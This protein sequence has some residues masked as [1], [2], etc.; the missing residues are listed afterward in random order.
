MIQQNNLDLLKSFC[1]SRFI[2]LND[3]VYLF[4]FSFLIPKIFLKTG[5]KNPGERIST[6]FI[7]HLHIMFSPTLYAEN[8]PSVL[9]DQRSLDSIINIPPF[10]TLTSAAFLTISLETANWRF[11]NS[12]LLTSGYFAPSM[13]TPL[14]FSSAAISEKYLY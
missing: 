5:V 8:A 2:F 13:L 3:L 14:T 6:I 10:L 12:V 1:L 9:K 4:F 11:L 7:K